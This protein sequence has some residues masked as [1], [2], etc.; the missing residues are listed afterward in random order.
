MGRSISTD[1]NAP[2]SGGTNL[3]GFSPVTGPWWFDEKGRV[4][5]Y[6]SVVGGFH[7]CVTNV[8]VTPG[9]SNDITGV[10]TLSQTNVVIDCG[11][12]TNAISFVAK[13]VGGK[14]LT[15]VSSTPSGKVSYKGVPYKNILPGIGGSWYATKKENNQQFLERFNLTSFAIANPFWGIADITNFPNIYFSADGAGPALIFN[16]FCML[17]SQKKI[18]FTFET[19]PAG[20]TDITSTTE[21]KLGAT[22]GSFSRSSKAT[23][24]NTKGFEEPSPGTTLSVPMTFQG[25]LEPGL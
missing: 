23:K 7:T 1:T 21:G 10:V 15:L 2:P 8:T 24:A 4:I 16:A 3:I 17:S 22:F 13:V 5:G 9:T 20:A 19:F 11:G 6:F 12:I 18:A 25:V 14:R